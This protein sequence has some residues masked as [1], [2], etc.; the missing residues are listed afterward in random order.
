MSPGDTLHLVGTITNG[1]SPYYL[2]IDMNCSG[3][4]GNPI[5]IKFEPN[6]RLSSPNWIGIGAQ[7]AHDITI[8]G[9]VNGIIEHTGEYSGSTDPFYGNAAAAVQICSA[10]NITVKNLAFNN[11]Y[12]R[13]TNTDYVTGGGFGVI[14]GSGLSG[15]NFFLND[16]F[17]NGCW[18]LT[19]LG[20]SWAQSITVSN[21]VFQ[22]YDHGVVPNSFPDIHIKNNYFGSTVPWDSPGDAYHHDCIHYFGDPTITSMYEISGNKLAGPN[23]LT[24]NTLIYNEANPQNV[25]MYNNVFIQSLPNWI[26]DG[27]VYSPGRNCR[28]FNNTFI[29]NLASPNEQSGLI[30]GGTNSICVNNIFQACDNFVWLKDGV[31]LT[32]MVMS[33]NIYAVTNTSGGAFWQ[34]YAGGI[35]Y[36]SVLSTWQATGGTPNFEANS[37]LTNGAVVNVDG[38]LVAGSPAVG[39]GGN[40][41][42]IFITD[43]TGKARVAKWT[44]GAYQVVSLAPFVSLVASPATIISGITNGQPS[45]LTW[46]SINATSVT[47]SGF[48]PVPLN[49]STN[50]SPA[51][52]TTYTVTATSLNGTN[53]ASATVMSL[54]AKPGIL[55]EH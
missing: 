2:Q 53:S 32:T 37:I 51:Q 54:P 10:A 38:T 31:D 47:L 43:Y 27:L 6:A 18:M 7:G 24:S 20:G 14:Y 17:S 26:S 16:V 50:V 5:T 1:V 15:T 52:N 22:N 23:G 28:I 33:N 21:C 44:V 12:I 46:S 34:V 11:N 25:L 41:S 40:L 9:G 35:I 42:Q 39:A 55:I 49:G 4:P 3:V 30:T 48:G 19:A 29:G 8:D 45:T 13:T 36:V